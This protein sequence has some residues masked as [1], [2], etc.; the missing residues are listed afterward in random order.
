MSAD[1]W[2]PDQYERFKAQRR[3]PFDDLRTLVAPVPGGRV[4]DLGCGTGELTAE[5]H[6]HV[7][8]GE[9]VGLDSSAAMIERS[10]PFAGDGLRFEHG[11][12]AAFPGDG[13][14]CD[15]IFSNAAL[16]WVPDHRSLLPKLRDAL[17]PG[18]QLAVQVPANFDH[19][20]HTIAAE[21]AAAF[22]GARASTATNVLAP[23][24]Y[25][26]LLHELGFEQQRVRLEVY[27]HPLPATRDVIEWV[28]GTLLTDYERQFGDRFPAYVDEFATR[29]LV[30]LGDPSGTRPYFYPF[31][32]IVFWARLPA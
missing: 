10:T 8:A 28:K 15:V 29:V 3:L 23:E 31:K 5:L 18:G 24:A 13:G 11:D 30:A 26:S 16:Q 17:A 27:G 6:H 32:R 4:V 9:T 20:S 7:Q 12:I 1:T 22:G 14:G 21:V 2:D 19:P 25:A